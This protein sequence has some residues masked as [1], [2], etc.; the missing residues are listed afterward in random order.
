MCVTNPDETQFKSPIN[1][2]GSLVET[3]NLQPSASRRA[4]STRSHD[5]AAA[6]SRD[7]S[8]EIQ[9]ALTNVSNL[10]REIQGTLTSRLELPDNDI[11][12]FRRMKLCLDFRR[13]ADSPGYLDATA[14]GALL[15]LYN[16]LCSRL[17]APA[18]AAGLAAAAPAPAPAA[19]PAP[20]AM[21]RSEDMPAFEEVWKQCELLASRLREAYSVLPY[22]RTWKG[23]SGT[24]ISVEVFTKRQFY[25][26]CPDFLYLYQQSANR[27]Q[28]L[29]S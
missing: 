8:A 19:A 7:V 21:D 24:V 4:S 25:K 2:E 11:R 10:A 5:S 6:A 28:T 12:P 29:D 17:M 13:M 9:E 20:Q 16:W 3:I 15:F 22:S 1:V 27:A 26:D 14:K 18:A 23:A